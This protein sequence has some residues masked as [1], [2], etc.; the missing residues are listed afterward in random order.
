[1]NDINAEAK[2]LS[3][4]D[5][6]MSPSRIGPQITSTLYDQPDNTVPTNEADNVQD[7]LGQ[8]DEFN[9]VVTVVQRA[10]QEATAN[11]LKRKAP[12]SGF[13][14]NR[15]AETTASIT[16][17]RAKRAKSS[18]EPSATSTT[19]AMSAVV[20]GSGS[21]KATP[22]SQG[23]RSMSPYTGAPPKILFS[24]TDVTTKVATMKFLKQ[25]KAFAA[26][27]LTSEGSNFL[28]VGT[29]ELKTTAKLLFGL[30]LQKT[31]VT[32]A[33]VYDSEKSGYLRRPDTYSPK[34]LSPTEMV[35]RRTLFAGKTVYFTQAL[36]KY[37]KTVFTDMKSVLMHAGATEV[38]SKPAREIKND[39][40]AIVLGLETQDN[41]ASALLRAGIKVYKKDLISASILQAQLLTDEQDLLLNAGDGEDVQANAGKKRKSK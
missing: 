3:D 40:A 9:D 39:T 1:M 11:A 8:I 30:V 37:Y 35:S 25:Q 32:D 18:Q 16:S 21:N 15:S 2:D 6:D 5:P 10:E 28:C 20:V 23:E 29:G 41:D 14:P 34:G 13:T 33:W 7:S 26:E 17:T 31:I 12:Q 19:R 38:G 27:K 4:G 24:N 36:K 22:P